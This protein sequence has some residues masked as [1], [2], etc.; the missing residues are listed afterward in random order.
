MLEQPAELKGEIFDELFELADLKTLTEED[1]TT[2]E[3]SFERCYGVELAA[4]YAMER[5]MEKGIQQGM[6]RGIQQGRE[7]GI[8]HGILYTAKRMK[9][10]GMDLELI[11]TATGYTPEQLIKM[12][13]N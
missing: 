3:K 4:D 13:L 5:G 2:Y 6:E 7:Q 1:M 11:V 8:Q 9:E 12:G 10:N